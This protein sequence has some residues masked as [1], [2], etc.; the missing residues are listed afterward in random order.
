MKLAKLNNEPE[1]FYSIQGE[2]RSAGKPAI[3]VRLSLCNLHCNWC[4]TD[5]TWNWEGTSFSHVNDS[6]A[7]YKKFAKQDWIVEKSVDEIIA[8]V[9]TYPCKRVILTGGEPLLQQKELSELA[10]K[11]SAESYFLEVE[12]NGTLTP[13]DELSDHIDQYN[14]SPKLQNS[15]NELKLRIKEKA[16][17]HMAQS[18]NATFKFVVD[19]KEDIDEVLQLVQVFKISAQNVYLMPQGTLPEMLK[20]KQLWIVDLCKQYG[21]NFTDRMHIHLYGDKRGV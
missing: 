15:N 8:L 6:L 10:K 1:I 2:G 5:Y 11:L 20:E 18:E 7:S 16:L 21:F 12:T 3:F 13:S 9:K 17:S 19:T 4:D 14:V